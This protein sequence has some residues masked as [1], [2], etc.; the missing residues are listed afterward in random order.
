V[1]WEKIK[2]TF[3]KLNE[4]YKD[5]EL[6]H[7]VGYLVV[8][9]IKRIS[10]IIK[11]SKGKNKLLFKK[12]LIDLIKLEFKKTKDIEDNKK[13]N[14]YDLE[15]I[16]YKDNRDECENL[17]LLLNV[18]YFLNNSSSNK[19]P[20]DLYRKEFWSV[21]H[22]NPQNPKNFKSIKEIEKWLTSFKK[23]YNKNKSEGFEL[24]IEISEILNILPAERHERK[25]S[26]LKWNQERMTKF[27]NV[28]DKITENLEL[29][30]IANLSLLDRNT[31][32]KLGNNIFIDKR[33]VVLDLYYSKKEE[34][35]FIPECTK[36]V[37]TKNFS[38]ENENIVDDLKNCW[39]CIGYA[40]TPNV[41]SAIEGVPVYV[42][43]PT[44]SWAQDVCFNNLSLI[45]NPPMPD[46]SEWIHKISNI[47]WSN[48]EVKSGQLWSAIR[49]YISASR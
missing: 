15:T 14:I 32:S 33:K 47:H 37:F 48:Q 5:I 21:E 19:F 27:Q 24:V 39:C 29:H 40:S 38:K 23:Y 35:V 13:R 3:N 17:L 9:K 4:W 7:Y 20:F 31:N 18:Q 36:D 43:E 11:V 6:Y 34:N 1:C 41:V 12:E 2:Q 46:R 10:E 44:K 26:E 28:I 22:I 16:N 25:L 42:E 45:E 49:T 30:G 8:T